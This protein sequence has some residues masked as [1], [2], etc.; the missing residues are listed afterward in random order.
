MTR[1]VVTGDPVFD[2]GLAQGLVWQP[3]L[4]MGFYPVQEDEE[5]YRNG[6]AQDYW[7]KYVGYART[8]LGEAITQARVDL[9]RGWTLGPVVDVGIGC[10]AFIE[11]M[12]AA[13]AT[14]YGCDV[15]PVAVTWLHHRGL[16][17][18]PW[19]GPVHAVSL[20]D[21]L[22]HLP[23]PAA[24]I[25]NVRELVFTSLPVFACAEDV[26]TSKHFRPDEHRW[27]W[28]PDGL[29]HWMATQGFECIEHDQRETRL[30]RESIDTFAFRRVA[31]QQMEA[32]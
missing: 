9:V 16:W 20:W 19:E 8:P 23:D 28:S 29:V 13:G 15:N 1:R 21:V 17:R 2:E 12:C 18:S 25:A 24:M 31:A 7:D 14:T 22:E 3:A 10:G 6:A 27:Y 30:G 32:V 11:A 4:G 26:L 5:P